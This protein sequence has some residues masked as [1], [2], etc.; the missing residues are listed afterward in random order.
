MAESK[1]SN[2]SIDEQINDSIDALRGRIS[3][4]QESVNNFQ[5]SVND[6]VRNIG[7][8]IVNL[9][10][11]LNKLLELHKEYEKYLKNLI[12]NYKQQIENLKATGKK[13]GECAEKMRNINAQLKDL[14]V[15]LK[16]DATETDAL[17]SERLN[18]LEGLIEKYCNKLTKE[19][20][21]EMAAQKIQTN[22][23][24]RKESGEEEKI[25]QPEADVVQS[26]QQE[27]QRSQTPPPS[28]RSVTNSL[29][30][31]F[32][33]Q[34][35]DKKRFKKAIQSA[36]NI[37]DN[38]SKRASMKTA[39]SSLIDNTPEDQKGSLPTTTLRKISHDQIEY[40]VKNNIKIKNDWW[41][42]KDI[43][44]DTFQIVYRETGDPIEAEGARRQLARVRN[45]RRSNSFSG[46]WQTPEKLESLSK[47]VPIRT[48]SGIKKTRKKKIKNKKKSRK[49]KKRFN[50]NKT[51][52][53]RNKKLKRR[54]RRTKYRRNKR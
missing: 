12:L 44:K 10:A 47:S 1:E 29:R 19:I 25:Q 52:R 23:K 13:E 11:C 21:E 40:L 38:A 50:K 53:K 22:F 35:D 37:T 8:L 36:S 15:N 54:R 48:Q 3:T 33:A 7:V 49:G 24:E 41:K 14:A 51:H 9:K 43:K 18:S 17:F 6:R 26:V 16:I 28:M 27:R 46:G 4:Y 45:A 31:M 39:Y 20:R 42:D 5:G 30:F 2:K 32:L 34:S